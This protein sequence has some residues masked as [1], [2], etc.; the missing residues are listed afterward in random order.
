MRKVLAI[1]GMG[2]LNFSFGL[3]EYLSIETGKVELDGGYQFVKP[4]GIYNPDGDMKDAAGS[5]LINV[6]PLQVK[7]GIIP[8]LDAELATSGSFT[9]DDAGGLSGLTQPQIAV[10][11]THAPLGLGGWV[12]VLLPFAVGD[13]GDPSPAMGLGI[14]G[15]YG[16]RFGDFRLTGI[17]GYQLNFESDDFKAGNVFSIYAKP[18]AMWTEFIGTYL[19]L[20]YS[21][22]GEREIAGNA[23]K[24]SDGNLFAV[25]PGVNVALLP[26][27][28]Y[29]VNAPITLMGKNS[30]SSWGI[31][32]QVYATLPH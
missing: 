8:G 9:N 25:V 28:A 11:Y 3:D 31:G 1:V 29:E 22:T 32:A 7:Y 14:G 19:G 17:A 4:T 24:D 26:W 30:G 13:Y 12:N 27:L 10:K 21:M 18:E 15:V 23:V 5:P 2:L 6:I 16:N 20:Q